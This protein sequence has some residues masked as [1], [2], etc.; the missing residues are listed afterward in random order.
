MNSNVTAIVRVNINASIAKVWDAL[1]RPE[2]IKQYF[3][4]TQTTTDWKPGSPISFEG[5]W[6]GKKYKDKGTILAIEDQKCIKYNYWSPMSG[7]ED[8]PENYVVI[9]Y[10]LTGSNNN[11]TL[12]IKQENI[13]DEK[14]KTHSEENWKKVLEGLKHVVEGKME[15][16]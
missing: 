4:G 1:T 5:E 7:I 9:T 8:K 10:T 13:P 3:F 14:T 16:A 15:H 11:V 6:Q 12:S 2:I